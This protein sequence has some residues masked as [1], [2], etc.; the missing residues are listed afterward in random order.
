[1]FSSIVP[2]DDVH[3]YFIDTTFKHFNWHFDFL[4]WKLDF[5]R[6]CGMIIFN[7]IVQ[8]IDLIVNIG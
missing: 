6:R 8:S 4:K 1:M 7:E 5:P 3:I 2:T